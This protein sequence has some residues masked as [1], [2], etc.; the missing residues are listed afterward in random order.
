MEKGYREGIHFEKNFEKEKGKGE[1]RTEKKKPNNKMKLTWSLLA[2]SAPMLS[3][4]LVVERIG[5]KMVAAI[6]P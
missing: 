5:K 6:V 1:R 3:T 2:S 4:F